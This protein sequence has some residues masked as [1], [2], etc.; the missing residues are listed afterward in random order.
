MNALPASSPAVLNHQHHLVG[1]WLNYRS[2]AE[3]AVSVQVGQ[4]S[5]PATIDVFFVLVKDKYYKKQE[6]AIKY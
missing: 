5:F 3:L 6:T 2:L 1:T 4:H